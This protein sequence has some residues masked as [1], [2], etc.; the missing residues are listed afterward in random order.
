[1]ALF[2][3]DDKNVNPVGMKPATEP[4]PA[5]RP[6]APKAEL[7]AHL[8][9]GAKIEGK[10]TFKGSVHIDGRVEGE[11]FA[12]DTVVLGEAAVVIAKI[13]AAKVIAHGRIEGDIEA[14]QRIELRAPASLTGNIR[15]P[16][17]IIHEGVTFEGRSDMGGKSSATSLEG[18]D[19]RVAIFP[20]E[21]R[22]AANRRKSEASS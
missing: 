2:S 7:N 13:T 3:K 15:T 11:I 22:G 21:E 17:L 5:P 4:V 20:T 10:L 12:E 18:G 14:S 9:Q 8:G 6:A 1:M 19:K 16:S